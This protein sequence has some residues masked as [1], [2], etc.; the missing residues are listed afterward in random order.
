M[1]DDGKVG[2]GEGTEAEANG[3]CL[4]AL[5]GAMARR[6]GEGSPFYS[7]VEAE[8]GRGH[9]GGCGGRRGPGTGRPVLVVG[10]TFTTRLAQDDSR[11]V[12]MVG[13][14]R[15]GGGGAA[16]LA[17]SAGAAEVLPVV[18]VGDG[19]ASGDAAER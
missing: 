14:R 10:E 13:N 9:G 5:P 17:V 8:R 2:R 15:Q 6:Q 1:A 7:G 11:A 4:R 19:A 3:S 12:R 16:S 18:E